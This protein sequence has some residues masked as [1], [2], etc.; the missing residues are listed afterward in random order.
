MAFLRS[1]ERRATTREP[2]NARGVLIAPGV[3]MICTIRDQSEG[4]SRLRLD[5]ALSLPKHLV[6]IDVAAGTAWEAE[7]AWSK[8]VEAGLRH[9]VRAQ[10]LK[11]LVPARLAAAREAWLRAGGR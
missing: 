3:E 2:L 11:G 9:Q 4:G 6:L 1:T 8:G 10:S 5:R 7:V